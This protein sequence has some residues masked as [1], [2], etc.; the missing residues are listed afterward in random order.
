MRTAE[1]VQTTAFLY[2]AILAVRLHPPKRQKAFGIAAIGLTSTLIAA[3]L[4]PQNLATSVVRDWLPAPLMLFVYWQAGQFFHRVDR[5]V[6]DPLE[7]TDQRLLPRFLHWLAHT[8][9][10]RIFS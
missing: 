6:Q 1:L 9:S 2:F 4:L 7:R 10:G 8:T 3:F 5:P